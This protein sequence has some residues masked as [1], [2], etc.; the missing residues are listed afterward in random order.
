MNEFDQAQTYPLGADP[1][2]A[3]SKT[4]NDL[5]AKAQKDFEAI[6]T[7]DDTN[8]VCWKAKAWAGRCM[9]MLGDFPAA[10]ARYQQ[11]FVADKKYADE[12]QRL[13]R[14][15]YVLLLD[16]L[17]SELKA[18]D[19]DDAGII[20]RAKEWIAENPGLLKSPEGYGV[21]FLLGKKYEDLARVEKD[22]AQRAADLT[23]AR[24]YYK[25]VE[26]SEN[27]FTDRA[28]RNK[29][30]II[31]AQPGFKGPIDQLKSFEDCY[32]RAQYE[33]M[34]Q[35]K[36]EKEAKT[37]EDADKVRQ[38]HDA[39]ITSALERGL[40]LAD[41][42]KRGDEGLELANAKAMMAFQYMNAKKYHEAI[43]VGEK[44]VKGDPRS[45]Q[46]A[47]TSVYV[48]QSYAE[49]V[50][51]EETQDSPPP[52]LK[53]D[54]KS[55]FDFAHYMEKTWPKEPAADVARHQLALLYINA[56]IDADDP[57]PAKHHAANVQEAVKALTAISPSYSNRTATQYQLAQ[58]C[59]G[60]DK[61]KL[62]PL[63]GDAEG[64]YRKRALAALRGVPPLTAASDPNTSQVYFL[65]KARLAQEDFGDKNYDEMEALTQTLLPQ[66]PGATLD[67]DP[68]KNQARHA[69][70]E[71]S[72]KGFQMYARWAKADIEALAAAKADP[73][74]K[75]AHY[76]KIVELLDPIVDDIAAGKHPELRNNP[77][78]LNGIL[79]NALRA[80]IQLNKP[81]RTRVVLSGYKALAAADAPDAGATEVLKKLVAFLP[82]QLEEMKHK[83]DAAA[84]AAAKKNFGDIL[85]DTIKPLQGDKLTPALAYYTAKIYSS[86]DQHKE[87]AD[88]LEKVPD[89]GTD[90][91]D[92]KTQMYH[93][94]RLQLG[95]RAAD[96]WRGSRGAEGLGR[97]PGRREEAGLGT[98]GDPGPDREH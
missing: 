75:S 61:E 74:D 91:Q 94:I 66:L 51:K 2:S 31:A 44:L 64:D 69:E 76:A 49:M 6:G 12:A 73:K 70:F 17:S 29:V 10:K 87:A 40:K 90:P 35:A 56:K 47:A 18:K 80:T 26:E 79:D 9:H 95:A 92:D 5:Y 16:E 62:P 8:P 89:P 68:A 82:P 77:T 34:E 55:L 36:E 71:A 22:P 52:E 39:V 28:R 43:A 72:I 24:C 11:I 21:R 53:A 45:S 57:D 42:S 23:E 78:L 58:F 86:M 83:D 84:L 13:T 25:Q 97:D 98:E 60:A 30:S 88:L 93:T 48:L 20:K 38:A 41:E 7:K 67:A 3:I 59:F 19:E 65:A 33:L 27:D 4:R 32:V 14:Y 81:E 63:E 85:A 50:G 37:P 54:R 96:E 1:T 46:A 15:F